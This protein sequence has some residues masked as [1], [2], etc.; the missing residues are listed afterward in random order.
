VL[1]GHPKMRV[2][3]QIERRTE[4]PVKVVEGDLS[5]TICIWQ[6]FQLQSL[7]VNTIDTHKVGQECR[8]SECPTT[9]PHR[10]YVSSQEP[11]RVMAAV[12]QQA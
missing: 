2:E 1:L 9:A 10:V 12:A 6:K 3:E 5:H 7:D 4:T 8:T 11:L